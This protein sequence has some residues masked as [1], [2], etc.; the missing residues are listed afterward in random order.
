GRIN[1]SIDVSK[2][3]GN[4]NALNTK[5]IRNKDLNEEHYQMVDEVAGEIVKAISNLNPDSY[6]GKTFR[7]CSC[8][9]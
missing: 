7:G 2:I 3:I 6:T 4:E 8:N 1:G 5:I 9:D